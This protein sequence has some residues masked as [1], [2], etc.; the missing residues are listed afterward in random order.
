MIHSLASLR[1]ILSPEL[2]LT[3]M[4]HLTRVFFKKEA[5]LKIDFAPINLTSLSI[6]L[7]TASDAGYI[8]S[9]TVTCHLSLFYA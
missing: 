6:S 2:S 1:L 8:S 5:L 3:I 7:G 4:H 9:A